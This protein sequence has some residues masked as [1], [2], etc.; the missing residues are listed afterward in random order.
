VTAQ[1]GV[2]VRRVAVPFRVPLRTAAGR[3]TARSSW[4]VR[5]AR[6]SPATG[7][8]A[9]VPG[10]A[11]WG[12]AVLEDE[13][14]VPV[15][16]ALLADLAA[17]G[18]VPAPALV[19]R[20]GAAGHAL[21]AAVDA[22]R[23]DL[24][25]RVPARRPEVGVNA[26]VGAVDPRDAVEAAARAVEDGFRTIKLKASRDDTTASLV[27]R[28][29]SVRAAAG[30]AV[31]LRLDAN[32]TWSL[33][34]AVER[35]RALAGFGLQY[36]EQPLDP[37]DL[38]GAAALRGRVG[39]PVAADEAVGSFDAARDVLDAGA[40]DV[41]VIKPGRVGGPAAVTAIAALAAGRGVPVVVS[42][43]FE[44]GVGLAAAL[45]CA[46]GLPD[47]DGWPATT[48]DHGLATAD[49]LVD[50]L[51]VEPLAVARGRMRAP[52]GRG[53]GALGVRVDEAGVDRFADE[54]GAG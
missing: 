49:L 25:G 15:L 5:L 47:V 18:L 46:A 44:T 28:V 33:E 30:D 43:L 27:E 34:V 12:E 20:A 40:A 35:L 10:R 26:V 21:R 8:R 19:A 9:G 13:R 45:A 14:D 24:E 2:T 42:S 3:W 50:D 23:Q 36:V 17:T 7:G 6:L 52:G 32:G 31:A 54:G 1:Y 48:R 22:A 41:L 37:R 29:A 38:A 51:L 11:G 16:E 4:L 39:V 53:A